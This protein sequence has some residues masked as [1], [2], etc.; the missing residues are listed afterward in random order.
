MFVLLSCTE[1]LH[2]LPMSQALF[3]LRRNMGLAGILTRQALVYMQ[4]GTAHGS[5]V[6]I[7]SDW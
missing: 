2:P 6:V 7:A 3:V 4:P 5:Q 1:Q